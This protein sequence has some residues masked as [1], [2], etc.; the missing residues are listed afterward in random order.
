MNTFA[1][2]MVPLVS[3]D[4]KRSLSLAKRLLR[5]ADATDYLVRRAVMARLTAPQRSQNS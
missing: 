5:L 4:R 3:A 1:T 2:I